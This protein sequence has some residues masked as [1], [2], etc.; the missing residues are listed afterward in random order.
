MG[1]D[2]NAGWVGIEGPGGDLPFRLV[3]T[4]DTPGIP[5]S[6]ESGDRFGTSVSLGYLLGDIDTVDVVVGSPNEDVGSVVDGGTVTIIR[7]FDEGNDGGFDG[8]TLY[9]QDSAGV[10]SFPEVGDRFGYSLDSMRT[11]STSRL[12][13][14]VPYEDVSGGRQ[15]RSGAAVQRRRLHPDR[16]HGADPG[17]S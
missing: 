6:T 3:L 2:T 16:R 8:A 11:G 12:A 13:V 15:R 4:Q 10:A 7:D 14:G 1:S 9:H 5:G 17:H